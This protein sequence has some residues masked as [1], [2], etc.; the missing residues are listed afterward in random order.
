[1]RWPGHPVGV[2]R[3]DPGCRGSGRGEHA[4]RPHVRARDGRDAWR[5]CRRLHRAV[6]AVGHRQRIGLQDDPVDLRGPQPLTECVG[7][8][9][10]GV[11]INLALRQSYLSS[12]SAT[13]AFWIFLAFYALASV[14]T[15]LMYV[16]RPVSV[17]VA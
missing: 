14:V 6:P 2:R 5:L 3:D 9:A 7:V 4:E 13:S 15:W 8:Q 1:R 16:R 17:P 11:V 10:G 12:H